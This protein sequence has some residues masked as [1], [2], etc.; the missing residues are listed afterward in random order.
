MN[1]ENSSIKAKYDDWV[2]RVCAFIETV[3]PVVNAASSAM[4]S[5]PVLDQSPE[6]LFL[7]HDAHEPYGFNGADRNR[8]YQGNKTFKD[9]H[10]TWRYWSRPYQS[11]SRI[12][13]SELLTPGKFML[14]NLFYFGSDDIS[15]SNADMG[16]NVMQKCIDF[17]EELIC[18]IIHPKVVVCFSISSVFNALRPRL[19][20][21]KQIKLND[22]TTIMQ[23][24]WNGILV[25]GMTH[26]SAHNLSNLYLDTVFEY[27]A[28]LTICNQN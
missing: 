4:Q 28:K 8:F 26:P 27:I 21:I 19:T 16:R 15:K 6:I 22:K 2:D 23:G 14:M 10:K 11:F 20:D 24:S 9:A 13:H 3:G 12:G 7:G 18:D 17:T 25:I 5:P 1:T